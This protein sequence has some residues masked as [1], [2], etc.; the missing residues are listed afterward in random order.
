MPPSAV[1]VAA[2]NRV[3]GALLRRACNLKLARGRR[4]G[5]NPGLIRSVLPIRLGN[6]RV[7]ADKYRQPVAKWRL[8]L[9]CWRRGR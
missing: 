7:G 4:R 9:T 2:I 1:F 3:P 6:Q 5:E 8:Q